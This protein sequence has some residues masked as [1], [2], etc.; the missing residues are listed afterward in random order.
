MNCP[1]QNETSSPR[2]ENKL[3]LLFRMMEHSRRWSF[4]VFLLVCGSCLLWSKLFLLPICSLLELFDLVI[5]LYVK[6]NRLETVQNVIIWV[7]YS[8]KFIWIKERYI[9]F[10]FIAKN[11]GI[12]TKIILMRDNKNPEQLWATISSIIC[13][14]FGV[15]QGISISGKQNTEAPN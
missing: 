1:G 10:T 7:L 13:L 2:E 14:R 11:D 3:S 12:K 9:F 5:K 4:S 8:C 15:M 6:I